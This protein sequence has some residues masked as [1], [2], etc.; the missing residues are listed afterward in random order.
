MIII[1]I[2]D[3]YMLH[4]LAPYSNEN[5]HVYMIVEPIS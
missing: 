1:G 2:S 4:N 5:I 3:E